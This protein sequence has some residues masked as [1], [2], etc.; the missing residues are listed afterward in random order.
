MN[1]FEFWLVNQYK[2]R[3]KDYDDSIT[4]HRYIIMA[5]FMGEPTDPPRFAGEDALE[6]MIEALVARYENAINVSSKRDPLTDLTNLDWETRNIMTEKTFV[7]QSNP[8]I[9]D[10]L[11]PLTNFRLPSLSDTLIPW[12]RRSAQIPHQIEPSKESWAMMEEIT[13]KDNIQWA[14]DVSAGK[15]QIPI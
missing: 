9:K 8:S 7:S 3:P 5:R 4:L 12:D 6:D 1:E 11:I 2:I 10:A 14:W 13:W 15:I